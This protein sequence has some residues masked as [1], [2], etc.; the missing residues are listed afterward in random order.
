M[1]IVAVAVSKNKVAIRLTAERWLHIVESHDYMAGF[2]HE[3]LEA[4]SDP[5][6]VV[7]GKKEELLAIKFYEETNLGPKY[8]VAIYREMNK[9]G[10]VITAFITSKIDK[11]LRR[12]VLWQ[13]R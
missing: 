11:I 4:I 12:K 10:F 5:D 8:L 3:V 1:S 7:V 6:Y 13:K 9:K 2:F